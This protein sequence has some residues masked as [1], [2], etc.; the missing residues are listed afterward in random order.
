MPNLMPS[1]TG[2]RETLMRRVMIADGRLTLT[3]WR[4]TSAPSPR[5]DSI[6]CES[7][8]SAPQC[9]SPSARKCPPCSPAP[10]PW[11]STISAQAP[12]TLCLTHDSSI[13]QDM[14][15]RRPYHSTSVRILGPI[16]MSANRATRYS[17]LTSSLSRIPHRRF[18]L[19]NPCSTLTW[20]MSW[21]GG[22]W[23]GTKS[24]SK[25]TSLRALTV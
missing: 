14:W 24:S 13:L 7:L 12:T 5:Q 1:S 16:R 4:W 22:Q 17:R 15:L 11:G 2:P 3:F 25:R 21:L 6:A 10:W 20:A 8:G 9:L 18:V 19:K 23:T